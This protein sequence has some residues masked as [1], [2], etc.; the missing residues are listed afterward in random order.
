[1][2]VRDLDSNHCA[3]RKGLAVWQ[4]VILRH[5]C[6]HASHRSPAA[7]PIAIIADSRGPQSQVEAPGRRRLKKSAGAGTI[8][9]PG[10]P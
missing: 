4:A 9:G 5:L 3:E 10:I 1:M 6:Y 8:P 2:P 7:L